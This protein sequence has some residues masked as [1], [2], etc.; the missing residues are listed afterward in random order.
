MVRRERF[1]W[2]AGD[3]LADEIANNRHPERLRENIALL[4]LVT[5][6]V[7][8]DP[9]IL[10][11]ARAI[12]TRSVTEVTTLCTWPVPSQPMPTCC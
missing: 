9:P 11:I 6:K 7:E 2:V 1:V 10:E 5:E 3:A 8:I 4:S 12:S